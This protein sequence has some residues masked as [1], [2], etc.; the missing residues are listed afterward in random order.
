MRSE[1]DSSTV[2]NINVE[3]MVCFAGK[4]CVSIAKKLLDDEGIRLN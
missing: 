4:L 1:R 2:V 3:D